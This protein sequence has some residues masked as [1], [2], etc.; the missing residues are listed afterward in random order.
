MS[1]PSR[2][3]CERQGG[4]VEKMQDPLCL[5]DKFMRLAYKILEDGLCAYASTYSIGGGVHTIQYG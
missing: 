2:R 3:V 1:C 4:W 5:G